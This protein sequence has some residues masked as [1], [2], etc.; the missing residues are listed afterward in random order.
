M[1]SSIVDFNP[2]PLDM[3]AVLDPAWLSR[4]LAHRWP[5]ARVREVTVV[6]TL[7]TMATKVRIRLTVEGN[8]DAP[9]QLCIKG[10][11]MPTG[12]PRSASIVETLFYRDAATTLGV[13][14][15]GCIHAALAAD[16]GSGVIVMDD[17]VAAG[18]TFCSA[19]RPFN[20]DQARDGLEQL[21]VLHA[22]GWEGK[23]VYASPW[24]PRFLDFMADSPLLPVDQ[25]QALLDGDR[26]KPLPAEIRNADRLHRGVVAL[27]AQIRERPNCLVHGDAHAG[28]I[29]RDASGALGIVDWQIL[30]KGEWAQ[31]VAYH[32]A[33]VLTPE[34]RRLH[35]KDL[36]DHYRARLSALG[37]PRLDAD[38][39][40][41]RYRA[42]MVYGFY[43]WAI[44]RKVDPAIT[45]EFVRRLGLA[46]SDLES[47]SILRI[48]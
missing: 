46:V 22:A 7:V 30:Q 24:I 35:E 6:E 8:D 2:A 36:L 42:A 34:D 48:S 4:V 12:A 38:E 20:P 19:L 41:T 18:G 29:Y 21:A 43:L 23:A 31:D 47:F 10:I 44:T 1:T 17:Q 39:A 13:H 15:P 9:S 11:L 25:L 5:E 14:V 45:H 33:A 40:W 37:G 3:D 27:S 32:L 16:G 28:N 26:G